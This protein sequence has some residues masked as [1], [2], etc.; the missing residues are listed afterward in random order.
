LSRLIGND[1]LG[2][3]DSV[4]NWTLHAQLTA[5]YNYHPSFHAPYSV[6]NSMGSSAAGDL[7]LTTTIFLGRKLWQGAAVYV[8]PEVTGGQGLSGVHGIAGFPNGDIY[9][10]GN[11]IPTPFFA[12]IYLQQV[13]ALGHSDDDVQASDKNQLAGKTPASK[14]ILTIGKFGISDFFDGNSYS[15]D[16]RSQFMNWSLMASGSWDFPAD[17]RGYTYGFVA[18]LVKP[19]WAIRTAF[20]T[21]PTIANG[22]QLD[23]HVAKA[24]SKTLEGEKRWHVKGYLGVIRATGFLAF[25]KA[26]KYTDA[27]AA[28]LKGDSTLEKIIMGTEEGY[29]YGSIKYGFGINVEQA[30]TDYLGVFMRGNWSD[31]HTATWAFTEIDNNVQVGMNMVGKLWQRPIDNWGVAITTNGIS[32]QHQEYLEAGGYGFLIG[33]GKLNYAREVALEIYY[34]LQIASFIAVSPDYQFIANPGYNK[35]RGPIHIIGLRV[36]FD[37]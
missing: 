14:I 7:S 27:T 20:V 26:P 3:K 28:L 16:A 25:T 32:K 2:K 9:R 21:E 22:A 1:R 13:I 29:T 30:L 34:K 35:D 5:I 33:D 19:L 31:G 24:N 4:A 17:V 18:E 6:I 12:R 15:H 10:V 36:H 11:P 37:I 8:N 23:L